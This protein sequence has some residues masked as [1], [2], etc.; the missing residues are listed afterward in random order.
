M[1]V[2]GGDLEGNQRVFREV[3]QV[4][5]VRSKYSMPYEQDMPIHVGRGL[6]LPVRE[7]WPQVRMYI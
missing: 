3:T 2:V 7:L 6:K 4:G 5:T 1:I